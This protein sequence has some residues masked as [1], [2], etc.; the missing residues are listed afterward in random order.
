MA[1]VNNTM[2]INTLKAGFSVAVILPMLA[3][4]LSAGC[5]GFFKDGSRGE[6][7]MRLAI[8]SNDYVRLDPTSYGVIEDNVY[9]Q[10]N[11]RKSFIRTIHDRFAQYPDLV[12]YLDKCDDRLEQFH[13]DDVKF[14]DKLHQISSGRDH[15]LF[16]Y[17]YE[18][19][20]RQ[21]CGY[22]VVTNGHIKAKLIL[23]VGTI[24]PDTPTNARAMP[25][26][27]KR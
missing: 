2:K 5:C 23:S 9:R 15:L 7:G 3:C 20:G 4:V 10:Y 26:E 24:E 11:S 17:V 21:E 14:L 13:R 6:A 8:N 16:Y 12:N 22:M 27:D 25:M 19:R 18:N 1:Y